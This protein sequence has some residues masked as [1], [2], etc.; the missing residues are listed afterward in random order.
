MRY[1]QLLVY[2]TDGRLAELLRPLT[3]ERGWSLREPRRAE[4]CLRLLR[5][6]SPSVLILQLSMA[7]MSE[8]ANLKKEEAERKQ[9]DLVTRLSFLERSAWLYPDTAAVV[10]G[11]AEDP[12]LAGL[13][14]DLGA[15]FVL[16]PPLPMERLPE[17]VAGLMGPAAGR[18]RQR[19]NDA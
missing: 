5:R 10:V 8:L 19:T 12:R 13:A 1:P 15:A 2:E 16:F 11:D 4:S 17:V 3:E 18:P 7:W 14:W 9:R 6:G